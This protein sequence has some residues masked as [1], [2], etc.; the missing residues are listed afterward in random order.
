MFLITFLCCNHGLF[1]RLRVCSSSS[2]R[3]GSGLAYDFAMC[4]RKFFSAW[5][6]ARLRAVEQILACL[7]SGLA[8]D[9]L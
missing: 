8:I 7:A 2:G 4:L 9:R 3:A 5:D 1:F 6:S